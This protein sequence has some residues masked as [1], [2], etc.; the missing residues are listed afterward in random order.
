MCGIAGYLLGSPLKS[1][2]QKI[3]S[4]LNPIR[5]RGPDDEGIFLISRE[6]RISQHYKTDQTVSAVASRLKHINNPLDMIE[7]DLALIHARFSIID[8]S[9]GGHQPF[10][11]QDKSLTIIFNG[12]IYNYIE[13]RNEL[14]KLGVQFHT[15][16]DTEVL[17]EGYRVW[18]D[19]LWNKMN[20]FWAVVLYDAVKDRVVFSRDR[21]GVAPLYYRETKEGL[22]FAS[23]LESLIGIDPQGI[24]MDQEV[25]RGFIETGLK[26][27]DQTTFYAEIKSIPSASTV[28]LQKGQC[29][30][31]RTV[32]Q[33]YWELPSQRLE[34]RDISFDTAVKRYREILFNAVDIRLRADV[35]VA[36]ELSGGMDSS[37]IVAAAAELRKNKIITYTAKISG[38]DEEPMARM[39]LKRYPVDF[40]VIQSVEDH[41][42]RDCEKFNAVMEEPYDNPNAYA[43]HQMLRMMRHDDV[44]VVITGAG[45]DEVFAGYENSFWPKAYQELRAK[46]GR[47]FWQADVYE[48][49]RRFKTA[50]MIR[51]TLQHYLRDSFKRLLW[52][53]KTGN[54][55]EN[56]EPITAALRYQRQYKKLSFHQQT[57]FHFNVGLLPFYMR[58]SDHFT[59]GIPVEHRF[60]LLDY[61]LV[62]LGLQ[63]PM[64][65]LFKNGWTKYLMRK[66]ME[67]CLPKEILWRKKKMG[68]T[69][70]FRK[71]FADHQ[72]T[73]EPLFKEVHEFMSSFNYSKDYGA[74]LKE[75]PLLLWRVLSTAIW[76]KHN[77]H[78]KDRV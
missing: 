58:S 17:V 44:R 4:L 65:Y 29:H 78:H 49:C 75:D 42:A 54:V 7:H 61:R 37:S 30:Y 1:S 52:E 57:L 8:L 12:E 55:K 32:I 56:S 6:K 15:S 10:V 35:K 43:H 76:M 41:F 23:C 77:A 46:G 20:G 51:K 71:Y 33:P 68:F 5:R 69:F 73:F 27:H 38:A 18:G 63:M 47:S 45:G 26:D 74:L 11:S 70:P 21:I 62:E 50:S 14:N 53:N 2:P 64:E 60:P 13:L 67:P 25:V 31:S 24:S 34:T 40:R 28:T 36:F 16:S 39:I 19:Q 48:F 59:M 66:A 9:E 72:K 22:Y 3:H